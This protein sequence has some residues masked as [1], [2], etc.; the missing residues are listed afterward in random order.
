[1]EPSLSID[2]THPQWDEF[3]IPAT[4]N[5]QSFLP[6]AVK[7]EIAKRQFSD[8][9]GDVIG[10]ADCA[11][12]LR[13]S[14]AAAGYDVKSTLRKAEARQRAAMVAWE[15]EYGPQQP[16]AEDGEARPAVTKDSENAVTAQLVDEASAGGS[17]ADGAGDPDGDD[18]SSE[19]DDVPPSR[20]R[21]PASRK[22]ARSSRAS[23]SDRGLSAALPHRQAP[24]ALSPAL[25]DTPIEMIHRTAR[26]LDHL[27]A[28]CVPTLRPPT[29]V[30]PVT[31]F[32]DQLDCRR[33]A[34]AGPRA[35]RAANGQRQQLPQE[36]FTQTHRVL[37]PSRTRL[38][39]FGGHFAR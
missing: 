6:Q 12:I 7:V 37:R 36:I 1:M 39:R 33:H 19:S 24:L 26:W 10:S 38:T 14:I 4:P 32:A 35:L 2:S 29:A 34:R 15:A 18:A 31:V 5:D 28:G 20:P 21:P 3:E 25:L 13:E 30:C 9:Y 11:R 23:R 27:A 16:V 17:S 22:L 8:R